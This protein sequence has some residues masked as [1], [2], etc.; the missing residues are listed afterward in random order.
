VS[1]AIRWKRITHWTSYHLLRDDGYKTV[2]GLVVPIA[3]EAVDI[4]RNE[5]GFPGGSRTCEHCAVMS[6]RDMTFIDID[7]DT[8]EILETPVVDTG[9]M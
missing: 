8:P 1:T 2:C 9:E 6:L 5:G 3:G 7:S 4:H